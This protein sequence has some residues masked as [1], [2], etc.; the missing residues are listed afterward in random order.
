MPQNCTPSLALEK[1]DHDTKPGLREIVVEGATEPEI[2]VTLFTGLWLLAP[3]LLWEK[4]TADWLVAGTDLV[5]EKN[6]AG[7]LVDKLNEHSESVCH[8]GRR[9]A[10]GL[11][12]IT[13]LKR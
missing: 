6:T 9:Q 12:G 1:Y 10:D 11:S 4:S 13:L 2:Y 3:N 8:R 7:W 5:W